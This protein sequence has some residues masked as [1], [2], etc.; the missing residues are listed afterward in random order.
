MNALTKGDD[1]ILILSYGCS[2]CLICGER[3]VVFNVF[4]SQAGTIVIVN[5]NG[6]L[7]YRIK[8]ILSLVMKIMISV[9]RKLQFMFR[10]MNHNTVAF[11]DTF[12]LYSNWLV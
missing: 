4:M 1:E 8:W 5:L 3:M 6:H 12:Q 11:S 7:S 10:W 2:M 9:L